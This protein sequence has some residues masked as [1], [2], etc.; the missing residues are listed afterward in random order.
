MIKIKIQS[1]PYK[2]EISYAHWD[3]RTDEWINIKEANADT[4]KLLC[5]DFTKEFFPFK[6]KEILDEIIRE[7]EDG[8][9]KIAI[10]FEGTE[11]EYQE[12]LLLSNRDLYTDRIYVTKSE[13]Y[14]E[15]ARDIL[16][17]IKDIFES[18]R[19]LIS[20]S[21]SDQGLVK[22][23]IDNFIDASNNIIPICVL[24]NYS[25]GKSTFI[26]ALIGREILPS[27]DT[28]TT[29]KVYKISASA[30]ED[31]SHIKF[32]IDASPVIIRF[33]D[34]KY[35][36]GS[37]M[38]ENALT[39]EL[40]HMLDDMEDDS[41][42]KKLFSVLE[43]LNNYENQQE[44]DQISEI[45]EIEV[46]FKDGPLGQSKNSFVILDTP[47]SNSASHY[48]HFDVLKKAMDNL[49]NGLP[50]YVSEYSALDSKDNE[51]LCNVIKDME[52]L[53]SRFT[54]I[55][56]NQADRSRL[57]KEGFSDKEIE[58]I[59]NQYTVK[60]L[61]SEGIYFVSSIMGLGSKKQG[62]FIDD[63][64]DEVFYD[65]KRKY[66]N[67]DDRN[68]KQ[69]YKYNVLPYQMKERTVAISSECND[70]IFANS[71]LYC[72]EKDI[73]EFASKYSAYNKCKQS[74]MF[75][76]NAI[77]ITKED[78]TKTKQNMETSKKHRIQKLEHDKAELVAN[79][80]EAEKTMEAEYAGSYGKAMEA[81][82]E[83]AKVKYDYKEL[84]QR[85]RDI[86]K[87]KEEEQKIGEQNQNIKDSFNAIGS[88][89][90]E[91]FQNAIKDKDTKSILDLGRGL[92]DDVSQT[93]DQVG[94]LQHMKQE[95]GR[96]TS[97]IIIQNINADFEEDYEKA[98]QSIDTASREYWR[99]TTEAVREKLVKM[100]AG[101]SVLSEDRREEIAKIILTYEDIQFD[102]TADQI[103]IKNNFVFAL[104]I[105]KLRIGESIKLNLD[106]LTKTYN[107]EMKHAVDK[108]SQDIQDYHRA[109]FTLWISKLIETIIENIVDFSPEL[110]EQSELIRMDARK[111]EELETRES[112]LIQY[113]ERIKQLMDWKL[114]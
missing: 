87:E 102:R 56:V 57:P 13:L 35:R 84:K 108:I 53:D 45:I 26:N 85:E 33:H 46:P 36:F 94:K 27:A 29:G 4:S 96:E 42:E 104:H 30:Y 80:E 34:S 25:A 77:A 109:N 91:H 111:I 101:S 6:V 44:E 89:L 3:E 47:G 83:D 14:L 43:T 18:L 68:Y 112:R 48:E 81:V 51:T 40:K 78:I 71:G 23:E 55:V 100:I 98:Q 58:K 12:L 105:G 41:L 39:R 64:Y 113:T 49:S 38:I 93:F 106:K 8:S 82:T 69:L 19:M 54:M 99:V 66:E 95:V 37:G 31:R 74:E 61:Y 73:E 110:H 88:N 20:Q 9:E 52:K 2:K 63:H 75:L 50:V 114:A 65:H 72:V 24:G 1:N 70:L 22:A 107:N 97:D 92:M 28:P 90:K 103:F 60:K 32:E 17:E 15:N 76:N 62:I 5:A 11:D 79:I 7:Y 59:M 86:T 16:P 67:P 21:V 10:V